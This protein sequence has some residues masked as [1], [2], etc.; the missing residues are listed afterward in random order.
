MPI[1][2]KPPRET[3]SPAKDR[4]TPVYFEHGRLE[5]DDSS[6]KW[7]GADRTVLRVPVA[8]LS[9]ILLGPGTTVTHAAIKACADCNTPICW[10]GE[11]A[12]RFYAIGITPTH[13]N[14]RARLQ[15]KLHASPSKSAIVAQRMF[16][17]RFPDVD[18]AD[19]TVA[20]LRGM[21][22]HRVRALYKTMG[23]K[24]GV[25]WKGRNYSP[26]NWD[27][28]NTINKAISAANSGLYALT[29]AIVCSMG[30]LPNLG[31]IHTSGTWPFIFDV[32]DVYKPITTLPAAFSVVS[33][34]PEASTS[35]VL[36]QL[37]EE[38][39]KNKLLQLIPKHIEEYIQ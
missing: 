17:K 33:R 38:I 35:E 21:E 11:E 4:W 26:D 24:Y 31:F 29:A 19:K 15:S 8:T 39:E 10:V 3:L 1:F 2:E 25:T 7:I 12:I 6:V 28:S 5:V 18:V 32:A 16:I 30:Y 13:D 9:T 14:S 27:T 37:K 34:N 22:G 36:K 20:E 23:E